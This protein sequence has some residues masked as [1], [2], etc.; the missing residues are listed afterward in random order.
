MTNQ[1]G[2]LFYATCLE[3]FIDLTQ[4]DREFQLK[5]YMENFAENKIYN[6]NKIPE[7]RYYISFNMCIISLKSYKYQF[8]KILEK[9]K[10]KFTS[11]LPEQSFESVINTILFGIPCPLYEFNDLICQNQEYRPEKIS[12]PIRVRISEKNECVYFKNQNLFDLHNSQY[13]NVWTLINTLNSENI[14]TLYRRLIFNTCNILIGS[15]KEKLNKCILGVLEL[16][17]PLTCEL[18]VVP[19]LTGQ[20]LEYVSMCGQSLIGVY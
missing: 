12:T 17:Y 6:R 10:S 3:Y 14:L 7:E 20:M 8:L 2:K 15:D 5:G 1:D 18:T 16:F 4:L 13:E 11:V 9:L 19:N